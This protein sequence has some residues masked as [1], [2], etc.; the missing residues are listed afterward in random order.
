MNLT[1]ATLTVLALMLVV[2]LAPG[3]PPRLK[4]NDLSAFMQLKRASSHEVFD[5]IVD[6][7]YVKVRKNAQAMSLL[8]ED[9]LWQVLKTPD[10]LQYSAEFR[11]AANDLAKAAEQ[12]NVDRAT[13]AYLE[14]T[15]KCVDCHR[16]VRDARMALL[17][18]AKRR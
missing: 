18:G 6:E 2:R 16:H 13:L 17:G 8:T 14:M 7:D 9:E 1:K 5:G 15:K 12:K 4:G 3:E 11:H 10:Y